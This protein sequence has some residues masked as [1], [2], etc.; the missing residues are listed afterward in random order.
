[1][2]KIHVDRTNFK[3]WKEKHSREEKKIARSLS[4][5]LGPNTY[6]PIVAGTFESQ[7]AD[8]SRVGMF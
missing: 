6:R 3:M 8:K 4:A 5:K 2:D 1:M 7:A